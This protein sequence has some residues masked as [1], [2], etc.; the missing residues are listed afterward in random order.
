MS[1]RNYNNLIKIPITETPKVAPLFPTNIIPS[2]LLLNACHIGNKTDELSAVVAINKPTV[3]LVT[4][5]SEAVPDS[6]ISIGPEFKNFR[7]DRAT[8]GGGVLAYVHSSIPVTRLQTAEVSNK[9]VLWLLLKPPRT[10]RPYSSIIVKVVYHPPGQPTENN[11]DMT[12]YLTNCLDSFLTDRPSSGIVIAGDFNKLNL[13]RLCNRFDLK[14]HVT[15]PTR[16]NNILD[17]YSTNIHK[18]FNPVQH[19]PPIGRSDHQCLLLIPAVRQKT[20]AKS[21]RIRLFTTANRN[22]LSLR[23][24]QEDWTSVYEAQEGNFNSTLAKIVHETIPE[25]TV[26]VHESDKLW[27]TGYIKAKINQ[28]QRAYARGDLVRYSQLCDT[29][30][31]L[32]S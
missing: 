8:A 3:I 29:V 4:W 16:G 18:L 9:E 23:I 14:K 5:L 32:I 19:L 1:T 24:I 13:T 11:N 28:R 26:R 31:G 2:F 21:K 27:M 22:A 17:Q 7:L 30:R 12:E 10:P 6:A 15:A 20:P 25:K